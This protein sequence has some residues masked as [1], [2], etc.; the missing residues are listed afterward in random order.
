MFTGVF[1]AIVTPFA[2]NGDIDY[3][4][5]S[6]LVEKQVEGGVDGIV[7]VGST[8]E[9]PGLTYE[10]HERLIAAAVDAAAGRITVIAGTGSNS[11]REAVELTRHA[12][13]VGATATLQ[14]TP[15]YNKP[16]Q[17]GLYRHFSSV[18][19]LGLPVV[20]Y[21]VPGRTAR[22][23]S[24]ETIARLAPHPNIVAVKES[25]G[26]VERVSDIL[27]VCDLD[28]LSGDD[29]LALPMMVAGAKGVVSVA[30]NLI[31]GTIVGMVHAALN[32]DWETA[33]TTHRKYYPLFDA[34][35]IDTNPVPVKAAM[36]MM[37][38]S[39][40][41]VYRLPLCEMPEAKVAQL[42]RTLVDVGLLTE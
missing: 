40:D 2:A 28:V 30:S 7:P 5:F 17:E 33:I 37:D 29:P 26:M 41:P 12:K 21:N 22:E 36:A 34:M 3:D 14:I 38:L 19:D 8:G 18:A 25:G 10:E 42:R 6:R 1:T 13:A 20:L 27:G 9:S 15:Y 4:A 35:F 39:G 16:S 31:P 23:I 32:G 11:T 24:V